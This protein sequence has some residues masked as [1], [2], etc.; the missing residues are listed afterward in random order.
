MPS[1]YQVTRLPLTFAIHSVYATIKIAN[2]YQMVSYYYILT[3]IKK[4]QMIYQVTR[5]P[6]TFVIHNVYATIKIM[7]TKW[8]L[9]YSIILTNIKK[10][11]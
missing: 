7:V 2:G 10:N 6:V 3:N 8:L 11:A 9:L 1:G 4:M 5:L